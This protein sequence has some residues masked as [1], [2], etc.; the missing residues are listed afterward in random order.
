MKV[1]SMSC[2]SPHDADPSYPPHDDNIYRVSIHPETNAVEISCIGINRL[3]TAL[4]NTYVS[5]EELPLWVKTKLALLMMT[6]AVPPTHEVAGVGRRMEE[7][8]YWVHYTG[9]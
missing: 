6:S 8:I 2:D 5:V 4:E 7:N 1:C 9:D 3:D